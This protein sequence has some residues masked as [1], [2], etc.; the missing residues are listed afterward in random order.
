MLTA[1]YLYNATT[2]FTK[3]VLSLP[4]S[5]L[6]VLTL[7]L[8]TNRVLVD[9]LD[10]PNGVTLSP[11][12]KT[13]YVSDTGASTSKGVP[14]L[15]G[16]RVMCVSCCSLEDLT[17]R[18]DLTRRNR[19]YAFDLNGSFAS[20]RRVFHRNPVCPCFPLS[21]FAPSFSLQYITDAPSLALSHVYRLAFLTE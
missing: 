14:S 18:R 7:T 20:N 4:F 11:D 17:S 1:T 5:S 21:L 2:E 8:P 12:Q 15:A 3:S 16:P 6:A 13:L 9:Q 10:E 19:S